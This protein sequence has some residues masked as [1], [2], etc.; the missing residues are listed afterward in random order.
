MVADLDDPPELAVFD[1]QEGRMNG[2]QIVPIAPGADLQTELERLK[3]E[4]VL[5]RLTRG[6]TVSGVKVVD[7]CEG[8]IIEAAGKYLYSLI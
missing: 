4:V 3:A 2:M 8:H 5:C 6:A 1:V 7:Y